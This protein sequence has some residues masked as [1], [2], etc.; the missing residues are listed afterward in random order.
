MLPR[1]CGHNAAW[2]L[3]LEGDP[4]WFTPTDVCADDP[5]PPPQLL[6]VTDRYGS[7]VTQFVLMLWWFS[8]PGCWCKSMPHLFF[9]RPACLD[10]VVNVSDPQERPL[11]CNCL[12]HMQI[13]ESVLSGMSVIHARNKQGPRTLPCAALIMLQ[14]N[15]EWVLVSTATSAVWEIKDPF[16][17]FSSDA[18]VAERVN[19][20]ALLYFIKGF[21]QVQN[22]IFCLPPLHLSRSHHFESLSYVL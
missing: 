6:N 2:F 5:P 7:L 17:E 15:A 4:P 11:R 19:Q 14:T 13:I 9:I 16:T 18:V 21:G 10:L 20:E 1:C 8:T 12:R 3:H 22:K